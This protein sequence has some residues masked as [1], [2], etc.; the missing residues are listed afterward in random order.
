MN[1]LAKLKLK[2]KG[3]QKKERMAIIFN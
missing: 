3:K 1:P 2:E